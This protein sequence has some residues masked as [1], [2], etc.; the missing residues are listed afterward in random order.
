MY[1]NK[2]TIKVVNKLLL[3]LIILN[4][5]LIYTSNTGPYGYDMI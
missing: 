2:L 3:D 4:Q 1:Y 5:A